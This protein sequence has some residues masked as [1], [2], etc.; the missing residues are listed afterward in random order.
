MFFVLAQVCDR[1]GIDL[2]GELA[3]KLAINRAR[4]WQAPDASGVVEHVRE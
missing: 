2:P 4:I 1:A 3:R